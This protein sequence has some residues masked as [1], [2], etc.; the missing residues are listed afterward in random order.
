MLKDLDAATV[1][2]RAYCYSITWGVGAAEDED[3]RKVF[4]NVLRR[5]KNFI[6]YFEPGEI[7]EKDEDFTFFHFDLMPESDDVNENSDEATI[8]FDKQI[9]NYIFCMDNYTRNALFVR[10]LA[11][12]SGATYFLQVVLKIA[13]LSRCY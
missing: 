13:I 10:D 3:G 2:A 1:A 7:N 8:I 12:Q 6:K 11:L 5:V 4:S 9:H